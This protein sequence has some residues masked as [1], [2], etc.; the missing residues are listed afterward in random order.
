MYIIIG[1]GAAGYSAARTLRRLDSG[2][3]LAMITDE[4]DTFYSRIDLP[5][6]IKAGLPEEAARLATPASLAEMGITCRMGERVSRIHP[7]AREVELAGGERLA[8]AKL[9]LATGSR[10][11]LPPVPG[12]EADGVFYLW[13]LEDARKIMRACARARAAVVA[14]AGLIGLKTAL[15]LRA[16]GL[17]VTVVEQMPGVMPRQLDAVASSLLAGRLLETGVRVRTGL[18]LES[19]LVKNGR[20]AGAL[21]GGDVLA[22]DMIVPAVGVRPDTRLAAGA[23]L[24]VG[25]GIV[26]DDCQRT[27]DPFIFAAGDAAQTVDGLTGQTIVPAVWPAAVEQGRVAAWNMKGRTR[28]LEPSLAM[29][30]VEIAGLSIVSAGDVNGA[31]GDEILS[32]QGDAYRKLVLRQGIVRGVLCLGDV[33]RAGVFCNMILRRTPAG[34]VDL[35]SKGFGFADLM[36]ETTWI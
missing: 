33:R 20:V 18:S 26:V 22:C 17:D 21:V 3:E 8:Y 13:K 15:A 2:L 14:G 27:S 11:I 25:R 12:L 32:R 1:Q 19:V 36:D 23:G 24:A 5:D 9:L 7:A 28:R 6:I 35:L 10:P 31:D 29:N 30:S 4:S 16:R 34:Q